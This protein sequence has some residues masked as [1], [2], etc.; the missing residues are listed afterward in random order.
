MN[1]HRPIAADSTVP[2]PTTG[3]MASKSEQTVKKLLADADIIVGGTRP[4]DVQVHDPRTYDRVLSHGTLGLGESYMDGWWDAKA[5]DEFIYRLLQ[6]DVQSKVKI[7]FGLWSLLLKSK[8]VNFQRWQ[9][10][11]VGRKHYDIGNDLYR[12][13][14]DKRMI[15]SCGYWREAKTLDAAQ[16]AKLDLICRKAMLAPGQSVLDI[17]SGWGGFLK[18]AAENYGINGTG[19]TVS[20]QQLALSRELGAGLLLDFHLRD[21]RKQTGRFDRIVS[22]GMFEHVGVRNYRTFMKK[23]RNLLADDG[24]FV[25]HTIGGNHSVSHGDPWSNKYIFPHGMLP[26]PQQLTRATE[27]LF[28]IEDWHNFG[29]DYDRTLMTWWNNFEFAWPKLKPHYDERFYRMWRYYLLSFAATFRARKIQLWQVV[30]SKNGIKG[31]Y[32]SIR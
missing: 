28:I 30:L 19:I 4:W 9:K 16:E 11:A 31:G 14:L 32:R 12:A 6:A 7:D 8:L 3:T 13:M 15:Y 27:G 23:A 17:G 20:E 18:Y 24:L 25:L 1:Q 26:S 2:P 21:Y 10:F 29:A 22:I 5:V